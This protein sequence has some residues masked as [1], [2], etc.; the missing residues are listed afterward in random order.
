MPAAHVTQARAP[1]VETCVELHSTQIELFRAP[2]A[3]ENVSIGQGV[4]TVLLSG[5]AV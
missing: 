3:S 2:T 5:A 4:H 1:A